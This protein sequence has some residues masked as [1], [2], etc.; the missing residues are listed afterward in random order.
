MANVTELKKCFEATTKKI[1]NKIQWKN[2]IAGFET[3]A[4]LFCCSKAEAKRNSL[5]CTTEGL[6]TWV[7]FKNPQLY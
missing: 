1:T 4:L 7:Y 5:L 6:K 3:V 2:R